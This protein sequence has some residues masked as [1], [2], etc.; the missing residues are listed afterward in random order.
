MVL[1]I[2]NGYR[3]LGIVCL[4]QLKGARHTHISFHDKLTTNCI[5]NF[6]HVSQS[7]SKNDFFTMLANPAAKMIFFTMLANPAAKMKKNKTFFLPMTSAKGA[8]R[9]EPKTWNKL[10]EFLIKT[11]FE[12]Q[13]FIILYLDSLNKYELPIPRQN[14]S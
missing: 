4:D 10:V 8:A 3:V 2:S 13:L 9:S 14:R 7:S 5:Q 12:Q 11:K 6:Y 1:Y